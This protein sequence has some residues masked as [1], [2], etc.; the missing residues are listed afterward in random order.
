MEKLFESF[1]ATLPFLDEGCL[2]HADTFSSY[3]NAAFDRLNFAAR[4]EG[5][6]TGVIRLPARTETQ[7]EYERS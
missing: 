6:T 3:V 4:I 7:Y 5:Y 1:P 2:S